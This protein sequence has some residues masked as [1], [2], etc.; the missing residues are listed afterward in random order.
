[1]ERVY[2]RG[3]KEHWKEVYEWAYG[4]SLKEDVEA[5]LDASGSCF[6][7]DKCIFLKEGEHKPIIIDSEYDENDKAFYDAVTTNQRWHEIKPWEKHYD[8]KPFDKVLGWDDDNPSD[9]RPDIFLFV[10][11]IDG[12]TMYGCANSSWNHVKPYNE[13]EYIERSL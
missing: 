2:V 10:F 3:N 5:G 13:E 8:P 12:K 9:I 7:C 4:E 11:N 1:M 6:G